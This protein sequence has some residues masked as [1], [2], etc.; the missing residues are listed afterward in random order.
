MA[1]TLTLI[2]VQ[3]DNQ[4]RPVATLEP[5]QPN[6]S[7]A[8]QER[9]TAQA[10]KLSA[11]ALAVTDAPDQDV[12]RNKAGVTL[13]VPPVAAHSDVTA[14]PA[15]RYSAQDLE[16]LIAG[17]MQQGQSPA[18]IAALVK[19]TTPTRTP[20]PAPR[21][22]RDGALDTASLIGALAAPVSAAQ[23]VSGPITYVVQPGDTLPAI[24]YRFYGTTANGPKI[25]DANLEEFANQPNLT[26]GQRLVIPAL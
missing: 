16:N 18:Y 22:V 7:L 21:L 8:T 3:K 10:R 9:D 25:I 20:A 13:S 19:N 1:V 5:R 6:A 2:L 12:T 14:R 17:A 23:A 24:S 26:I 15:T 11:P 4:P